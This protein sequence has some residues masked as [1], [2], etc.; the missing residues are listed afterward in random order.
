[1]F[2]FPFLYRLAP[3]ELPILMHCNRYR[4]TP[5]ELPVQ[6]LC[7][8]INIHSHQDPFRPPENFASVLFSGPGRAKAASRR[9]GAAGHSPAGAQPSEQEAE[10]QVAA[11][12]PVA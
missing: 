3:Q 1:M 11:S 5:Q 9:Q 6:S 4:F 12:Q 8:A 2:L 7:I 10:A